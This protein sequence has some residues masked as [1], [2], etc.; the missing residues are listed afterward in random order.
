M[1]T[2]WEPWEDVGVKRAELATMRVL[3]ALCRL[4]KAYRSC[5]FYLIQVLLVSIARIATC[6]L[7]NK[8]DCHS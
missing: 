6:Y 3:E 5:C 1:K 4:E 2:S 7:S 8:L